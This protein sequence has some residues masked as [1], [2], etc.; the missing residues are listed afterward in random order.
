LHLRLGN[1]SEITTHWPVDKKVVAA[2]TTL[3]P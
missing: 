2:L 1:S 3:L